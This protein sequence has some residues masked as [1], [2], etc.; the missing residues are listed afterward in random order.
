MKTPTEFGAKYDVSVDEKGHARLEKT[1]FDS[2]NESGVF[3]D[4]IERYKARIGHYPK[5]ALADQIYRTSK[6]KHSFGAGLIMTKLE[7]TSLTSIALSVLA[8]NIFGAETDYFFVLYLDDQPDE[9]GRQYFI[10]FE[11]AA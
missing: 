3:V 1:S 9:Y 6:N 10:E 4:A 8:A 7:E 11:D 2:Y 5:R